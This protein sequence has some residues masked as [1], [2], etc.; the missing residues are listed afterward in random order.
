MDSMTDMEN[1][2]NIDHNKD[3]IYNDSSYNNRNNP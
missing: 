3:C 2:D 1:K